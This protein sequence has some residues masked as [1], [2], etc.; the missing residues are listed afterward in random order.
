MAQCGLCHNSNDNIKPRSHTTSKLD[1]LL[2]IRALPKYEGPMFVGMLIKR[3]LFLKQAADSNKNP[4]NFV[5]IRT[6]IWHFLFCQGFRSYLLILQK[7]YETFFFVK[8]TL[9]ELL[10]ILQQSTPF[11]TDYGSLTTSRLLPTHCPSLL[12]FNTNL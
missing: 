9:D 6:N 8:L 3:L 7:K 10:I 5:S 1:S 2:H 12:P 4:Y 11:S